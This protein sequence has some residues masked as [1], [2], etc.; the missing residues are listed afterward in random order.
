MQKIYLVKFNSFQP[1]YFY[2]A[3][4]T[5]ITQYRFNEDPLFTYHKQIM[6]QRPV[7]RQEAEM[8]YELVKTNGTGDCCGG[9][10]LET[11]EL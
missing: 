1:P 10:S 11:I 8:I 2:H 6:V 3:I 5:G 9:A 7:T 4:C